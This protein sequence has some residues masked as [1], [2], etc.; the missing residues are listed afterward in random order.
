MALNTDHLRST[1]RALDT[2]VGLHERAVADG[3]TVD[4]EVFRLAIVKGFEL[5][6]EVS[7]KLLKR[8]LKDFGH[9][10]RRLEATPIKELLRLGAEHSLLTLEEV[11]R[12][13]AYRDNRNDTAHD[14]GEGFAQETLALMPGFILDVRALAARLGDGDD[15]IGGAP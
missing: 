2:A 7:F 1:L 8:R 14:Y 4:Q 15:G 9:G 3:E 12:W 11:E 5:T 13:L 6:Q 10:G